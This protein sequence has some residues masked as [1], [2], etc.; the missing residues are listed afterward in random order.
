[1]LSDVERQAIEDEAAHSWQPAHRH[2]RRAACMAS[3]KII[4]AHRGYV[5]DEAI[6]DLAAALGMTS[7]EVEGVATFYS[8]I[9]RRPVGKRVLKVCDSVVCWSLAGESLMQHLERRLGIKRG[10]TTADGRFTLLPISC[11]GACEYAPVIMVNDEL[12]YNVT[13]GMLDQILAGDGD[14]EG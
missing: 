14:A 8:L 3:L 7:D 9:F 6:Q 5:S 13:L 10:E 12:I 11:L 4:Q 2:D 1:M